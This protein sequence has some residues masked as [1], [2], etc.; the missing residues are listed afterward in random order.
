LLDALVLTLTKKQLN[1]PDRT[2]GL[3]HDNQYQ[4]PQLPSNLA[5]ARAIFENGKVLKTQLYK[6]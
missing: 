2:Y 5:E 6:P 4:L 1:P 3:A